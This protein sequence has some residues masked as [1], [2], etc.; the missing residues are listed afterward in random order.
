M[1]YYVTFLCKY[2]LALFLLLP[3]SI[4]VSYG[5]KLLSLSVVFQQHFQVLLSS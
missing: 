3:G 2:I 5:M 4:A 1:A